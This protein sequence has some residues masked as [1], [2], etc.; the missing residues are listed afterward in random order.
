MNL[1]LLARGKY[2][3]LAACSDRGE[4]HLLSFLNAL[5]GKFQDQADRM[6]NLLSRVAAVGPPRNTDICHRIQ[7][8]I[9]QFESG[10]L[11]VLWFYGR[12]RGV[13]VCSHGFPKTTPKT[14][15]RQINQAMQVW[16]RYLQDAASGDLAI[17][18]IEDEE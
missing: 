1:L 5:E 16:R 3:V 4:F 6:L 15:K 2:Q 17:L 18:E 13:I 14:P 7:D 10:K 11:R 9:W 8:D 12:G